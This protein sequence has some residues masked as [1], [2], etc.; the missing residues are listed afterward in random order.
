MW[1]TAFGIAAVLFSE[2]TGA[3]LGTLVFWA[4]VPE[5]PGIAVEVLA[6]GAALFGD[7]SGAIG[8]GAN[9]VDGAME[10]TGGKANDVDAL[11]AA[12]KEYV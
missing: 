5:L 2:F 11:T 8:G 10:L 7:I 3:E 4:T 6:I 1:L 12:K 9:D